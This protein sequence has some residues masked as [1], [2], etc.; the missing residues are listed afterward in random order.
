MNR[1]FI[2]VYEPSIG[3]QERV[4]VN[5]CLTTG[6]VSSEGAFVARFEQAI[7]ERVGKAHGVAVSSGTAALEAAFAVLDLQP[8]D[9]VILPTFTIISCVS[10]I[11]RAGAT[12]VTVDCDPRTW[13]MTADVVAAAVTDKTKAILVVHIYGL[14]VDIDPILDLAEERK[15]TVVEDAAQALGIQYR[16]RE[17]GGL[18]HISILSFYANKSVTSGEG[19][20]VLTDSPELAARLRSMRQLFLDGPQRFY[21][22]ELGWNWKMSNIQAALGLGQVERLD[23]TARQKREVGTQYTE[24][25]AGTRGIEQ[26]VPQ[27]EYAQN[28]YWVYGIVLED[29]VPFDASE[30]MARLRDLDIGTRPF[31]WPMH[32]QPALH[33]LGLLRN[34][35][36]PNAERIARRGLYLPSSPGL[37]TQDIERVCDAVSSV[38]AR[39]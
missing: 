23:E 10:A 7:A 3:P 28:G 18:G 12:P 33:K 2:P 29:H 24:Y 4:Y 5:E 35:S 26:P 34:Q 6:W 37:H 22:E 1:P 8:G 38:I 39:G 31:F 15:I 21:H 16:G 36:H 17:C 19:G 20:M 14:P 9:E 13:N 27:P 11:I 30:G 32:E 25:L